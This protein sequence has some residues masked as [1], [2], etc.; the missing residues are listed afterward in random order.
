VMTDFIFLRD[1]PKP[2][3]S[4]NDSLGEPLDTFLR[5]AKAAKAPVGLMSFSSMPVARKTMLKCATNM[6]EGSEFNMR[7]IYVGKKQPDNPGKELAAKAKSFEDEGR[8]IELERA[9]FGKLFKSMEFFIIQGG[10]GTSVE[11]LRCKKPIAVSGP[12]LL[13]Q[14]WWGQVICD[15]GVGPHPEEIN[16]FRKPE[17]CVKFVNDALDPADPAG[18]QQKAK[19][20]EWGTESEDGVAINVNTFKKMLEDEEGQIWEE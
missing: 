20:G 14:R 9:D 4:T 3:A 7:L 18:Y 8:F 5:N 11:A 12:L 2:G 10:L 19:A 16:I 1:P 17:H 15:K 6:L 13:D